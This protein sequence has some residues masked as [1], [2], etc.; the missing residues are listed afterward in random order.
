MA[1]YKINKNLIIQ[2]LDDKTVMFDSD[3]SVLY[4][5]NE[6]ANYIF[7]QIKKKVSKKEIV[8]KMMKRYQAKEKIIDKD[9]DGIIKDFI[10]KKIIYPILQ[11]K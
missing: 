1:I 7:S 10:K 8:Q 4:T 3:S 6:T 11:K 5:L 9:V 2:K